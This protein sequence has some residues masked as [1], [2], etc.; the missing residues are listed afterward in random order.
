MP[1][2]A[3]RTGGDRAHTQSHQ[4]VVMIAYNSPSGARNGRVSMDGTARDGDRND[5]D[6]D[7][8]YALSQNPNYCTICVIVPYLL[9][10]PLYSVTCAVKTTV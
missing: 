7:A 5:D 6:G 9:L 2:G 4:F 8:L 10:P 3:R 1:L